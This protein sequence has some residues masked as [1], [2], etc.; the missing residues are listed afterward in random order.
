MRPLFLAALVLFGCA[1]KKVEAPPSEPEPVA[2]AEPAPP[3]RVEMIVPE[4]VISTDAAVIA[5]GKDLFAAKGCVA[6]HKLGGGKLVGPDLKGVT[7]RRD[8]K[9]IARMILYPEQMVKED[10]VAK[11]LFFEHLVPMPNQ[12]IDPVKDLP[13]LL[14]YL[15]SAEN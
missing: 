12:A 13:P 11:K 6:C 3:P 8:P 15:K 1:E 5:Q 9:W 4:I 10:E 2:A 7:A 14:A